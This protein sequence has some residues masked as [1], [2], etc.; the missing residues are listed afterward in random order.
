[1]TRVQLAK[2]IIAIA[3]VVSAAAATFVYGSVGPPPETKDRLTPEAMERMVEGPIAAVRK[4]GLATGQAEFQRLLAGEEARSGSDSVR[5]AD[6]LTSFGVGLYSEWDGADRQTMLEASRDYLNLA[7]SR[8]RNAFGPEHPEVAVALHSF[9][10]VDIEL[11]ENRA[12]PEAKA[13]LQ[14]ALRIRRKTL[15]P[16]HHETRATEE[17]LASLGTLTPRKGDIWDSASQALEDAAEAA[18]AARDQR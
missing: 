12:T 7:V 5:V 8:Y 1:V 3:L 2:I 18:E 17:R 14:E 9:A 4:Y 13:A 16:E 11:H 15:G 6:L 10:D